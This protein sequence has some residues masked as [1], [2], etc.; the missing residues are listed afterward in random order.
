VRLHA[1]LSTVYKVKKSL[2]RSEVTTVANRL[3]ALAGSA[4]PIP[5]GIDPMKMRAPK[6]K[7]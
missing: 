1:L 4:L 5:K 3:D 6:R 7:A 2:N